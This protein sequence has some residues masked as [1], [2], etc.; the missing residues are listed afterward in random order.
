MHAIF[1]I[2]ATT[3]Q[4]LDNVVSKSQ[5]KH[6]EA[7][8]ENYSENALHIL[9]EL[10]EKKFIRSSTSTVSLAKCHVKRNVFLF[11]D[12]FIIYIFPLK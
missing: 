5:T 11:I 7:M 9:A 2:S 4:L 1:F 8:M 10:L 12:L 3:T 6:N